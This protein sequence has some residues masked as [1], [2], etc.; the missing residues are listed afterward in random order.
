MEDAVTIQ[1]FSNEELMDELD[2]I[3]SEIRFRFRITKVKEV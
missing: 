3:V 2:I 1:S